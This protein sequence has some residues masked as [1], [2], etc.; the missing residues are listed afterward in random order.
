MFTGQ[1]VL[2]QADIDSLAIDP[3]VDNVAQATGS[4]PNGDPVD[5]NEDPA[6]IPF[7]TEA[8]LRLLKDGVYTDVGGDGLTP[9]D[10]LDYTSR[11]PMTSPTANETPVDDTESVPVAGAPALD[12]EKFTN[13]FDA[14]TDEEAA[15]IAAGAAVT[16][17]YAVTNTGN[18]S[19]DETEIVVT[20][21]REGPIS[22]IVDDGDGDSTLAPG[23]TWIYQKSGTAQ[24]L[25][26]VID[27]ETDLNG[28]PLAAGTFI[29]NQF[30]DVGLTVTATDFGAM[31]FDSANPTGG[32]TD[33]ATANLKN[34]L[35][36]SE[37]G[38][39]SDPDDNENGG[40]ITLNWE[41]P[42]RFDSTLVLDI[43]EAGSTI[44]TY[45]ADGTL[46][47]TTVIPTTGDGEL[48]RIDVG[49]ELVSRIE[50]SFAGSGATVPEFVITDIYRNIATVSVGGFIY[51]SDS[52]GYINPTAPPDDKD[53]KVG[54]FNTTTD[55]L[56]TDLEDGDVFGTGELT[57]GALTL[58]AEVIANSDLDGEVGSMRLRLTGEGY[59]VVRVESVAPYALFGDKNGD[60]FGGIPLGEG[61]YVFT[62]DVF[63]GSGAKGA[64][65][66]T[67]FFSFS[68]SDTPE[69]APRHRTARAGSIGGRRSDVP[70][71]ASRRVGS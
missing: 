6:E 26:R 62:V 46:I 28:N 52:S 17:T 24:N 60:F 51:D 20:D 15:L 55:Q 37:D 23:E 59:N 34:I 61:D 58:S 45:D 54:I 5:S 71:P 53:I 14:D 4:D 49:D 66:D 21:D 47:S 48:E 35:I 68:V 50:Y 67:C 27:W 41:T 11:S 18:V 7:V 42:V 2:S 33:L 65:L 70:E 44:K 9:G 8:A 43:E 13:G 19:F 56:V 10:T 69:L 3:L 64:L 40:V 29:T 30:E 31:I 22:N 1:Y 39:Q 12:I 36:I 38:D 32:D 16:W 63:S 25:V 57:G